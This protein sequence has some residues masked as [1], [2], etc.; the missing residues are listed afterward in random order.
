MFNGRDGDQLDRRRRA[1]DAGATPQKFGVS[2]SVRFIGFTP[3]V[4]LPAL[5]SLAELVA[6]PSLYEGFGL[7]V[8]E[9]MACGAAV[10]TSN[11]S[12]LPEVAGDAALLIEARDVDALAFAMQKILDDSSLRAQLKQRGLV[13]AQKF[14]WQKSAQQLHAA[15]KL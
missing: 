14:S 13:Q 8:L 2:A 3:D 7:P 10:V 12:S 15:F 9:A 5:Y 4:D 11:N 1:L 6:Y